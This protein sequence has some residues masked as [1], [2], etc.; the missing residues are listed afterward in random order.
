MIYYQLPT[1]PFNMVQV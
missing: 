1:V